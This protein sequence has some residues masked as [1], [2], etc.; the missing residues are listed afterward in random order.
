M[1]LPSL[2]LADSACLRAIARTFFGRPV[3]WER[4]TGPK[5]RPPPRNCGT[6]AEPW[7]APPVP[8]CLYIFLPVR[9]ISARPLALCVPAW[10]LLSCHCTQRAR[11]SWRGSRPKISSDSWT[12]P[13][14]LPSRVV[15]CSSMLR[16]LLLGRRFA[17]SLLGDLE[18]AGLRRFLRQRLLHRVTD[19]DPAALGAG[20]GAFDQDQAA[21]DVG[22][23]HA[24]I[25]RG[26]A[27][28]AHMAGHLLVLPSL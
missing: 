3:A 23:D 9:Q 2:A 8:F 28:D 15:T 24:Q 4:T 17:S 19:A 12:E 13:A 7:R 11:M 21:L 6:R 26:D 14:A 20:N 22:R 10:R 16:A 25:E 5:A 18:L 27:V 1:R